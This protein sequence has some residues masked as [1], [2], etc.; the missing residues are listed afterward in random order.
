MKKIFHKAV[1]SGLFVYLIS[2]ANAVFA[3]G[4]A[5]PPGQFCNPLKYGSFEEL[6]GAITKFVFNMA[7]VVA[8]IMIVIAGIMFV[9]SAGD[10]EKVKKAREVA[11]YTVIGFAVIIAASGLIKVLQSLLGVSS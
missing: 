10:P 5:C 3:A 7:L 4:T 9:T 8:P 11:L 1:F 6:V 2:A